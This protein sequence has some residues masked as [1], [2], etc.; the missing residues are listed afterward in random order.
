MCA[1]SN[2]ALD[3]IVL[4]LIS[5][6]LLDKDG[7][8]FTPNIVRVGVNIHHSVQS[9]AL[10]NLVQVRLNKGVDKKA[11]SVSR[12]ERDRQRMAILEEA[13]IVCTTMAFSGGSNF[14]RL[15]RKFDVVVV[16]E[17]AQAVEPSVLVPLAHGGAKQVFLVGDPEQLPATVMSPLAVAQGYDKSLFKRLQQAGYPVKVRTVGRILS[18]SA[19]LNC[20]RPVPNALTLLSFLFQMLDTQYRMH[21]IIR[22]FPSTNFYGGSLKDGPNVLTD[23]ERG[24]HTLP[25]FKPLVFYDVASKVS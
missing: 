8:V 15:V 17:A 11:A 24:W 21:P 3:E 12:M 6:G 20:H 9:V 7:H 18:N 19:P 16:D 14:A 5:S 23:T 25:A 2:S 4:R 13:N 1:P 10:D 22:E